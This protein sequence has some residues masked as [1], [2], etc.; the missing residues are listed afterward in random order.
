LRAALGPEA[1]RLKSDEPRALRLALN[2][3]TVD[4]LEFD[5]K[6]KAGDVASLERATQLYRGSILEDCAEDWALNERR[7]REQSYVA[8]LEKLSQAASHVGDNRQAAVHLRDALAIDPYREDLLRALMEALAADGNPTSALLS[9]RQYRALLA[10]ELAGEPSEETVA[11]FQRLKTETKLAVRKPIS[12]NDLRSRNDQ[13]RP[14][15][16]LPVPFTELIGRENEVRELIDLLGQTRLLTLTGTGGIGKTRLAIRVAEELEREFSG[17]IYF[18]DL[19]PLLDPGLLSEAVRAAVRASL[20]DP[21]ASPLDAVCRVIGDNQTLIVLDNCEHLIRDCARLADVLLSRCQRLKLL[22][23]S[24]QNLGLNGE[25]VWRAPSLAAPVTTSR[26]LLAANIAKVQD[27]RGYPAIRLFW[28]RA[29]ASES[30]FQLTQRNVVAVAKVCSLLDGIPLAIELAAVWVKAM[31]VERIAQRLTDRFR[32]LLDRDG[33]LPRGPVPRH[34]TL[35]ASIDWSYDLLT[36]QERTLLQRLSIFVG[37]WTLEAAEAICSA[38]SIEEWSVFGLLT[39]LVD[40]S[41]VRYLPHED[42]YRMLETIR[43]Y[44][45]ERIDPDVGFETSQRHMHYFLELAE[46][47]EPELRGSRQG[48][49]LDRLEADHDNLRAALSRSRSLPDESESSVRLASALYLFWEK[50]GFLAEGREQL[51]LA[52]TANS[53][54]AS[55]YRAKALNV[56]AILAYRQAEFGLARSLHHEA[57]RI[58]RELA[59]RPGI[60]SSLSNLGVIALEQGDLVEAREYFEESLLLSREVGHRW[61]EALC[62]HHLGNVALNE[63]AYDVARGLFE[64]SLDLSRD[65]GD[66]SLVAHLLGKLSIVAYQQRDFQIAKTLG[67]ERL[68][69]LRDLGDR[70]TIADA[71]CL[72]AVAYSGSKQ[73]EEARS[74]HNESLEINRDLHN[75]TGIACSLEEMAALEMEAPRKNGSDVRVPRLFGAAEA[76]RESIG[77][78]VPPNLREA[79]FRHVERAREAMD[80]SSFEAAWAEGRAMTMEQAVEYAMQQ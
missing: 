27:Y 36:E 52:L 76:L 69:I 43:Q 55:V 72:L 18:V 65:L 62:L 46:S 34:E 30:T 54:K 11:L 74:L 45:I 57:L 7:R 33:S 15:R 16:T 6:V 38:G 9:Y 41:L 47:A 25:T 8:A 73:F 13:S 48:D 1:W 21:S 14:K 44:L 79:H 66:I 17:A 63:G 28:E 67:E 35:R 56:S 42:R 70:F 26:R 3:V 10:R 61:G 29:R 50:R 77:A 5:A 20:D 4:A 68:A 32:M 31:P 23:T 39:S 2:D 64:R 71:L 22:A 53:N 78:P 49:C 40:K 51:S 60:A 19:A 12:Q 75:V 80:N 59:D 24:R 58:R 37:G